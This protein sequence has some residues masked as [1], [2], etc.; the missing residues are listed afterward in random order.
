MY[1]GWDADWL[2]P[3]LAALFGWLLSS[4]SQYML[5]IRE[6]RQKVSKMLLPHM[7]QELNR[8]LK[9]LSWHRGPITR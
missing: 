6:R 5:G 2:K 7:E 1:V 8:V 4:L 9:Y 3:L